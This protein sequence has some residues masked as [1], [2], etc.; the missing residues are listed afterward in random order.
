M[1]NGMSKPQKIG[2]L[3][4]KESPP[5]D[6]A[7]RIAT[8][9]GQVFIILTGVALWQAIEQG[10]WQLF[11]VAGTNALV[12]LAS[13]FTYF[14]L[15]GENVPAK[16]TT[17][18]F[19]L[20]MAVTQL[21]FI[22][23]SAAVTNVGPFLAGVI[24]ILSIV[25]AT[26]VLEKAWIN[27][28][29]VIGMAAS[30][31]AILLNT[32]TNIGI[33]I[34]H[35]NNLALQIIA[36]VLLGALTLTYA[37]LLFF[38]FFNFPLPVK[39]LTAFL[40]VTLLPL[41]INAII[42][43]NTTRTALV[44]A[45]NQS[46]LSAAEQTT[47]ALDSFI[48]SN[49]SAVASEANLPA[50]VAYMQVSEKERAES[51]EADA[52]QSILESLATKDV[53][54]IVSY[55]LLDPGGTVWL[56]TNF[57][58]IGT[59]E[60]DRDY[61][62][63]P[64][65]SFQQY[66]S[67]IE[68]EP[69]SDQA[70]F[71]FSAP[72]KP[73]RTDAIGVL[74]IRY[75]RE[76][77]NARMR[78]NMGMAQKGSYPILVD[79]NQIRL[80]DPVNTNDVFKTLTNI[81]S[82]DLTILQNTRRL[83]ARSLTGYSSSEPD[84]NQKILTANT[85]NPFLDTLIN[86]TKSFG[87]L[88]NLQTQ[89]WKVIYLQDQE[90]VLQPVD[91]QTRVIIITIAG[92]AFLTG[93][94]GLALT[95]TLTRPINK[96]TTTAEQISSGN[97]EAQANISTGDETETLADAF[98]SMTAQLR[99]SIGDL[100]RRVN[101]RT[102]ELSNQAQK[103]SFRA[104][105]LQT[106]AEVARAITSVQD[107]EELLFS[108][109]RITSQRFNFYHV[110]IFLI[111]ENN[112]YALLRAANSE[113]G[114]RMLARQHKLKVGQV[115]I[116]GYVTAAGK[117]RIATDV[118]TDAYFFNNPDLPLTRSEM[119]LPLKSGDKVIGALD[120]QSTVQ[121]AFGEEDVTLFS[122]LADQVA[123]AIINNNLYGSTR[124][125]LAEAED[126]MAKYLRQEWTTVI[127]SKRNVGYIYSTRGLTAT[128][129]QTLPEIIIA[130][131]KGE[132]YAITGKAEGYTMRRA[133]LAVPIKLRG[134]VIGIIDFQETERPREWQ[135][136]EIDLVQNV[137]D[138]VAF[139]LENARLFED[140]IRRAE[141]E[142]VAL[143]ITN[144]IRSTTDAELIMTLA[145]EEL[146][147]L[148]NVSHAQIVWQPPIEVDGS[149]NVLDMPT[150]EP[151]AEETPAEDTYAPAYIPVESLLQ[152]ETTTEPTLQPEYLPAEPV[153]LIEAIETVEPA[154]P[155]EE[156]HLEESPHMDDYPVEA[157]QPEAPEPHISMPQEERTIIFT[158]RAIEVSDQPP[159]EKP[160]PMAKKPAEDQTIIFTPT[161]INAAM[162]AETPVAPLT[163]ETQSE[164]QDTIT[165]SD[166]VAELLRLEEENQEQ[167]NMPDT[168]V[169][170]WLTLEP[171]EPAEVPDWL[172]PASDSNPPDISVHSLPVIEISPASK[173]QDNNGYH[174]GPDK[175]TGADAP[176]A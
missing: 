48:R 173:K 116:V 135:Q 11:A 154:A 160:A 170:S 43:T 118:G 115:G 94:L 7:R 61:V 42:T 156:I 19:G 119:A 15:S 104:T 145:A 103:M 72:I 2:R 88:T 27:R 36:Y 30:F 59:S 128:P 169:P 79:E 75:S 126:V 82:D 76:V 73:S 150:L 167:Y 93:L 4:F 142:R 26:A 12:I 16:K 107:L 69:N 141:R 25:E 136:E 6:R 91:D 86:G 18:G 138:Q 32:L 158:P 130:T 111:D 137:I 10:A 149:Q 31:L 28:L 45:A 40:V 52:A 161:A 34:T 71:Y 78:S 163:P 14:F 35:I 85:A 24:I 66:V 33:P 89:T 129:P 124:K 146:K 56:S 176:E 139:A 131:R 152:E 133:A 41:I 55:A 172:Q 100:E 102:K 8:L 148:L 84:L 51:P 95:T 164:P 108:V 147:N 54:Y 157:P 29:I 121:N 109:T 153:E 20:L 60:R 64:L 162:D 155:I 98:N 87:A 101:E 58:E 106:L 96:L 80:A 50:L 57:L 168:D 13:I 46:L 171:E 44:N 134:Q 90:T 68:F 23:T 5:A 110:G 165:P 67:P 37:F 112:E 63:R 1:N 77:L 9:T 151:A 159:A 117:P 127:E 140:T 166:D 92:L 174:A 120:V 114:Q 22:I 175:S 144:K 62:L 123:I 132:P 74:R 38:R 3:G 83:P 21:N 105:Q 65:I 122:T 70:Y 17:L 113:G 125:A 49:L 97:L 39:L 99:S 53:Q 81:S 47:S 143:D